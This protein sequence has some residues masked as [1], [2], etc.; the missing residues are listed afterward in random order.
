M[1][2][3]AS[4]DKR[5]SADERSPI[6]AE[7]DV[8]RRLALLAR[9][10]VPAGDRAGAAVAVAAG[11]LGL[12]EV[13]GAKTVLAFASFG[14]EIPTDPLLARLLDEG[15]AV[16]LPYVEG[17][18]LIAAA[19]SSLD[20]LIPGYRG[21]REPA[22]RER[23]STADVVIVPGVAF[24]ER[25][26]RLGYGGGF[27]DRFLETI[28]PSVPIVGICFDAQI[29]TSVPREGHDRDVTVVVT[30]RRVLRPGG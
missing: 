20:D 7:K 12:R 15:R 29:V 8:V 21:I 24:D 16:L 28:D 2:R 11:V 30:E 17:D 19:I 26:G 1:S 27:Y 10:R 4:L 5:S 13:A 6:K 18:R 3:V 14:P 22:L 25:G 9:S 23:A